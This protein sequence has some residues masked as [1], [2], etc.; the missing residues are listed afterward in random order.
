MKSARYSCHIL[1]NLELPTGFSKCTHI[2]NLKK[3][4]PLAGELIHVGGRT[5]GQTDITKVIVA[6]RNLGTRLKFRMYRT[7]H[8]VITWSLCKDW[9]VL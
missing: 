1:M 9:N 7:H 4:F 6:I 2:T 5:E 8:L 3:I